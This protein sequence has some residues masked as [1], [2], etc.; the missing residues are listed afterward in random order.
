M[1]FPFC[2]CVLQGVFRRVEYNFSEGMKRK[3]PRMWGNEFHKLGL[4]HNNEHID[5]KTA[6]GNE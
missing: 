3:N 6:S 4:V 1:M 2:Y 5:V